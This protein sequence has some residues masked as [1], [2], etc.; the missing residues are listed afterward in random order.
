LTEEKRKIAIKKSVRNQKKVLP[1]QGDL[2][3]VEKI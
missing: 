2:K 3:P 1:G